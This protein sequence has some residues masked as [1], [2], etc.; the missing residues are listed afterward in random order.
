VHKIVRFNEALDIARKLVE[1]HWDDLGGEVVLVRDLYGRIRV[2]LKN[3]PKPEED[4]LQKSHGRFAKKLQTQLGA[5]GYNKSQVILY[6]DEMHDPDAIYKSPD[7]R[8]LTQDKQL[9]LLDRQLIAQD[10][11]RPPLE[12][13]TQKPRVTFFGLKGGVGRSTALAVW[14]WHLARQG[15]KI[16]V[17]DLDLESPGLGSTLLPVARYP[18]FGVVDWFVENAVNQADDT[19]CRNIVASSP[20]SDNLAGEIRVVPAWG[21]NTGDYL[22]KLSRSYL[23]LASPGGQWAERV[24][25]LVEQLEIQEEPDLVFLDSRAGLHDI[26]AVTVTRL[27]AN[28]FLFAVDSEQTWRG[29]ELLFQ[30]WRAHPRLTDF[31]NHLQMVAALVPETEANAYLESFRQNAYRLFYENLYEEA[32]PDDFDAFNFDV[33]NEDAPH[34]P[35]RVNWHRAL[36]EFDPVKRPENVT[37]TVLQAAFADFWQEAESWVFLEVS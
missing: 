4:E 19:F 26:S 31:R 9:F 17:F 28:A 30:H 34:N 35:L 12:K 20:L 14:A 8:L 33:N 10:W 27:Q 23:E 5:F 6:G 21:V 11:D 16:L 32:N 15:K 18:D 7:K 13:K 37:D 24:A 1:D 3:K 22:A 25:R 36:Q 2:I 29:Y